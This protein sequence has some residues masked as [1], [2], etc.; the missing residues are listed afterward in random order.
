MQRLAAESKCAITVGVGAGSFE[1]LLL[2]AMV[3][4]STIAALTGKPNNG[5]MQGLAASGVS[6]RCSG[7]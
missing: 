3:L 4:A 2:G 6:R 7:W 5:Y 1:A